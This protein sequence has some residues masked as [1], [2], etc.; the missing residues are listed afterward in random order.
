MQYSEKGKLITLLKESYSDKDILAFKSYNLTTDDVQ[1]IKNTGMQILSNFPY[2]PYACSLMTALWVASIRDKTNIPTHMIAGSLNFKGKRLF[3]ED[4]EIKFKKYF[5][6]LGLI[7][8]GT[9]GLCLEII[10]VK[11]LYFVQLTLNILQSG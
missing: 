4:T 8:M 6:L 5:H 1:I 9:V 3:G 10:L 2:L 11:Y 7:G